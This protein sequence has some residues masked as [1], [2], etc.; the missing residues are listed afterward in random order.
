[1]KCTL[2]GSDSILIKKQVLPYSIIHFW[3]CTN[4][5]CKRRFITNVNKNSLSQNNFTDNIKSNPFFN[6]EK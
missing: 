3:Q 5:N 6:R 1:M 2:C 4:I